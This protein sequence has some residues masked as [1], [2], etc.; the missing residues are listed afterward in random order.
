MAS[1]LGWVALTCDGDGA[2]IG[3]SER[4]EILEIDASRIRNE[5][6]TVPA[7]LDLS[8]WCE[9][10]SMVTCD[11][12]R[13]VVLRRYIPQPVIIGVIGGVRAYRSRD[14]ELLDLGPSLSRPWLCLLLT[15]LCGPVTRAELSRMLWP[16][17]ASYNARSNLKQQLLRLNNQ[18]Q[19]LAGTDGPLVIDIDGRL[20]VNEDL[21]VFDLD[22]L[23]AGLQRAQD[24]AMSGHAQRGQRLAQ[25]LFEEFVQGQPNQVG[26]RSAD[27]R[28]IPQ[29]RE[30]HEMYMRWV[31][32]VVGLTLA[33]VPADQQG[34]QLQIH[35]SAWSHGA[36]PGSLALDLSS[37]FMRRGLLAF[38][39]W[40]YEQ[41]YLPAAEKPVSWDELVRG[42]S[43]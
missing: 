12:G 39:R 4:A 21:V 20:H 9:D 3:R 32:D 17:Y 11:G 23:G 16:G 5:D 41:L 18:A 31:G 22:R 6:G 1:A 29:L 13:L 8:V 30:R 25:V 36:S 33:G 27:L 7:R 2:V 43:A 35:R 14:G 15:A 40:A 28:E 26:F 38:S 34:R 10:R 19:A 37:N 42:A 24:L